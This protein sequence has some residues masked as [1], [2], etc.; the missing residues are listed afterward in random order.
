MAEPDLYN[1]LGVKRNAADPEIKKAYRKLA[2]EFHPDKNP[3]AGD[4]FKEISYAYEILSDPRKREVYD[5][6]G[7]KGIQEGAHEH[8]GMGADDIF[9]HIFGG[10]GLFGMPGMG[11]MRGRRRA[12][13]EDTVH[14]LKVSLEDL[15]KGKT[16]KLQI[17]KSVICKA[18][19]GRG[20]SG[21][22]Q[23]CR[24]CRG[25]GRKVTF[26]QLGPGMTQQMQSICTDCGGEGE[27]IAEKDRCQ[28]CRG[29]K[30]INES[31]VIE[32]HVDKGMRD[33]QKIYLRGE[34]DQQPG[35]EPG[36]VI[37]VLQMKPHEKFQR[38]NDDLFMTHTITITEALCGF[39]LVVKHLDG[40]ELVVRQ[41]AGEVV[42]PGDFKG[43]KGEG[44]P[45]YRNPF[46]KGVLFIKFDVTFP[47]NNFA[48]EAKLKMLETLLPNRPPEPIPS[49]D[50][51]EVVLTD[52]DPYE[53][54]ERGGRSEAYEDDDEDG[55]SGPG[56]IQCAQQ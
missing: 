9:S 53:R 35:V 1:I 50:A 36:D 3:E 30:V 29:K 54:S 48:D 20:G 16:S 12:R 28:T 5:R 49:G 46:E 21:G 22:A 4:R 11:G 38:T 31:K 15:Y 2:M 45:Q 8:G 42:K 43:I 39:I 47:S 25:C 27:T 24:G 7:L 37:I 33:G 17:S 19:D 10:G 6:H 41:P 52:Y 14:P 40:R 44:M 55:H 18:C 23:T 26:R 34:G 56:G 13:G 51:E 32:A